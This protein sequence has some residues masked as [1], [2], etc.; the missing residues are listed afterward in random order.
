MQLHRYYFFSLK[1]SCER[2]RSRFHFDAIEQ[3]YY[4][5]GEMTGDVDLFLVISSANQNQE[6]IGIARVE[7]EGIDP[8]I[9]S[10]VCFF[11]PHFSVT[12]DS[13]QE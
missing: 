8:D 13:R 12:N 3:N 4:T 5:V 10:C 2:S 9:V 6:M 11:P 1:A 7:S